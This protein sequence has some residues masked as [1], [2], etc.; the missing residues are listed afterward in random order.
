MKVFEVGEALQHSEKL[1]GERKILTGVS[2]N[3]RKR[4]G[5]GYR[6]RETNC[7]YQ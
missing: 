7:Y 6:M 3:E 2:E 4:E 5:S 1:R